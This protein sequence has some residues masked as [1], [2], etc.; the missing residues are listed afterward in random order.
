MAFNQT[1]FNNFVS[2]LTLYSGS[3]TVFNQYQNQIQIDNLKKYLINLEVLNPN[4]LLVGEAPGYN[5]CALT[6]IPFT[7]E[8]I[9]S[10]HNN[11]GVLKGAKALGCQKETTATIVWGKLDNLNS[12]GKLILPPILWNIFPFHSH[13]IANPLS[14]RSPITSEL[15]YGIGVLNDLI[16]LFPSVQ[17]VYAIGQV[18][19]NAINN[20]SNF[21]TV[22]RH[23]SNGGKPKFNKDIDAIYP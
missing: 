20:L 5:G 6:G 21:V 23:P 3:S 13:K 12:L 18:A 1:Q 19:G 4:T 16:S 9:I 8:F 10:T 17:S 11:S 22:I 7:S 15:F 14:N 2:N